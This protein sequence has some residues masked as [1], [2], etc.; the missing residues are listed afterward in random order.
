MD[1]EQLLESFQFRFSSAGVRKPDRAAE[2]LLAKVF[3]C[4]TAALH[5]GQTPNPPSS[6]QMMAIIREL[7][8]LAERIENGEEPQSVL[9]CADF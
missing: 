5:H 8:T 9:G 1:K 3:H 4:R 7:E 2:E 6:G